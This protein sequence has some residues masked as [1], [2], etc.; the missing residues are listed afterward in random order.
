MDRP[1]LR[2]RYTQRGVVDTLGPGTRSVVWVQGCTLHCPGCI[3]PEM[4]GDVVGDL[5]DPVRL[6][7][8]LLD[9]DAQAHLTVSGGEPTE[10]PEALA[11]LL[12]TAHELGRSTWV[13]TGRTLEELLEDPSPA[14]LDMLAEIDVLVDG[15]FE[16]DDAMALPYRGSTNQRIMRLSDAIPREAAE[17]GRP[18]KVTISI[19][20]QGELVVIGVPPPGFL[21]NL[22]AGLQARGVTVVPTHPWH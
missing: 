3:V 20:D 7:H 11:L 17:G 8:D 22:R 1:L 12:A 21:T 6:A 19:D 13:Y 5:V 18:G 10:Q 2:V 15:R 9:A 14:M 4:W 16:Q